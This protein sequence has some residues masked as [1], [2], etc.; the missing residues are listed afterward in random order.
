[1]SSRYQNEGR[2]SKPPAG[3]GW[4]EGTKQAAD[5][6]PNP[7][8][9]PQGWNNRRTDAEEIRH[10]FGIPQFKNDFHWS[11]FPN[12]LIH[13]SAT[14][15]RGTSHV[16]GSNF[17]A[18]GEK[19]SGK[20]TWGLYWATR[21]MEV[22]D[23]AVV[24][25]GSP[26]RSEWLPLKPWTR[27]FLPSGAEAD[28][29]WKPIDISGVV[30]DSKATL[31][32]QV[33]EVV[34]YDDPRDLNDQLEPGTFNV[35]YPDPSFGG[36]KEIVDE[37]EYFDGSVEWVPSWSADE[38]QEETPLVHWWFAWSIARI[39][40]G[41]Y[42]WTSLIFDETADLAPES[43]R[44]DTHET[45]EKVR[46][47][48]RVMAD[49]RKFHFSLYWLAHHEQNLHSK[50]RRTIQ[51]RLSMPDGTANPCKEHNDRPPV[52]FNQ[53]PMIHDKLSSRPVGNLIFWTETN[54]NAI[55]WS[56]IPD[57]P[58]DETRWLKISLSE[59]YT[60]PRGDLSSGG[61]GGVADD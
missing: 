20:S 3:V 50:I 29:S 56:D 24:W 12:C 21:L 61:G 19:G 27:L 36:C 48:R 7:E 5:E 54:F 46:S 22:N 57:W 58:E 17:L 34:Y 2:N 13:E 41:P 60:R 28:A 37:S 42:F 6:Y 9:P 45:Y 40:Y 25:R 14:E 15:D 8:E 53:I 59:P 1:M 31:E 52:G 26:T 44:A 49:S 47:L 55:S 38:D 4:G 33:R 10:R 43:A 35:V 32:D 18:V 23:E 51:W 16:G 30:D 39:E 11:P